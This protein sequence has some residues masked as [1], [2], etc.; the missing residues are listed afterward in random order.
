[1]AILATSALWVIIDNHLAHQPSKSRH[2]WHDRNG[3]ILLKK[4]KIKESDILSAGVRYRKPLMNLLVVAYK[5]IRVV[6]IVN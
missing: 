3:L 5:S 6:M 4:S 1:M 2:T